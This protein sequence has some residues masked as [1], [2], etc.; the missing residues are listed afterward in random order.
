MVAFTDVPSRSKRDVS[1]QET[2]NG[3]PSPAGKAAFLTRRS[4]R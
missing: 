3:C 2:K 1:F 4:K